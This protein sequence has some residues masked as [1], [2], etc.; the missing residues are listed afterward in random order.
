[1]SL[2]QIKQSIENLPPVEIKNL[3]EWL[4]HQEPDH[5]ELR[6]RRELAENEARFKKSL[7][8]IDE[9][10][11]QYDGQ[12]V[13]VENGELIAYGTDAKAV[14]AEARAKGIKT[15]FLERVKAK[16]DLPFGSW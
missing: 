5:E 10:R 11:E 16:K 14:F 12:F 7:Q 4:D 2:D 8:W 3:R 6:R 1:M 15:P 13:V 9:H